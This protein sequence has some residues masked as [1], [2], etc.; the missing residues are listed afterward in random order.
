LFAQSPPVLRQRSKPVVGVCQLLVQGFDSLRLLDD[1]LIQGLGLVDLR[2]GRFRI[3]A[4]LLLVLPR[5]RERR[6]RALVVALVDDNYLGR[7][8]TTMLAG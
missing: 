1:R 2:L 7:L 3:G 6:G 5:L 8:T 4:A